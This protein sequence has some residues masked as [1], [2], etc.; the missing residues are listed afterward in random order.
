MLTTWKSKASQVGYIVLKTG[1]TEAGGI[2]SRAA[3]LAHGLECSQDILLT[4]LEGL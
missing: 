2:H 4:G 3:S 1:L